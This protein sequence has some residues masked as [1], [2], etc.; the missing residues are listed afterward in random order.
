MANGC[1]WAVLIFLV[2]MALSPIIM[3]IDGG[4][5]DGMGYYLIFSALS[6]WA[7]VAMFKSANKDNKTTSTTRYRPTNLYT[8][9]NRTPGNVSSKD[10]DDV[11]DM[12]IAASLTYNMLYKD[13]GSDD[14]TNDS[15]GSSDDMDD[16]MFYLYNDDHDFDSFDKDDWDD[17][18]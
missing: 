6:I 5:P 10:E 14:D 4:N 18:W 7:L 1:A 8:P 9:T 11:L 13:S 2:L 12:A 3:L 17:N 15:F 16:D